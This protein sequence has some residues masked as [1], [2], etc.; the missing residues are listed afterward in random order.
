MRGLAAS[1]KNG[2]KVVHDGDEVCMCNLKGMKL[3]SPL[4]ISHF[5]LSPVEV[6]FSSS[7]RPYKVTYKS[8]HGLHK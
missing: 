4:Y 5:S 8:V 2:S 7:T 6:D 1:R 3:S